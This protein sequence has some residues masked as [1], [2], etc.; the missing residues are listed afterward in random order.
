ME[1]RK[2]WVQVENERREVNACWNKPK[3]IRSVNERSPLAIELVLP[4][5]YRHTQTTNRPAEGKGWVAW[6]QFRDAGRAAN[7]AIIIY[8]HL[9]SHRHSPSNHYAVNRFIN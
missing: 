9:S 5:R 3:Q 2:P 7:K 6:T 8:S 4:A 1:V